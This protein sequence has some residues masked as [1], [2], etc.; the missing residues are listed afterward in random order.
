MK[1]NFAPMVRSALKN[2]IEK[3]PLFIR[4]CLDN[5]TVKY[6]VIFPF[7]TVN[8]D[9]T[10]SHL[11]NIDSK[12]IY[13][14]L[15]YPKIK[16][17]KGLLNWCGD[18]ELSDYQIKTS[19][20]FAHK[21]C[22]SIFDR[23]FQYKIV[24]QILPTNEYLYRYKVK[25]SSICENC[26]L[27]C[28]TVV[29]RLYECEVIVEIIT[30]VLTFMNTQCNQPKN[31]TM[32]EYLFGLGGDRNIAIDHILLELKK[33]I[34]YSTL[35]DLT[36]PSFCEHFQNKIRLLIIKEKLVMSENDKLEFFF[37]KW[38]NFTT[39]YDFRGPDVLYN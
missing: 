22:P 15:I 37:S 23:V 38:E 20:T 9:G 30:S 12:L 18:L 33:T 21:C 10:D 13:N 27:E 25:E 4:N 35:E 29:H 39:I 34:F 31:I 2:L 3:I 11:M 14:I 7:Q 17:P 16:M 8:H 5:K 19:L 32:V 1:N 36:N 28:D 26:N 24:T 6:T